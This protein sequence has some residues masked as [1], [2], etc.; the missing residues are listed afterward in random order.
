M[1]RDVKKSLAVGYLK[2]NTGPPSPGLGTGNARVGLTIAE[3][4]TI[5]EKC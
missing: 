1:A 4:A 5:V 3:L 2:F